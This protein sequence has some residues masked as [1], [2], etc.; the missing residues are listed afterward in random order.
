MPKHIP[1]SFYSSRQSPYSFANYHQQCVLNRNLSLN[2]RGCNLSR[3]PSPNSIPSPAK[4]SHSPSPGTSSVLSVSLPLPTPAG[5]SANCAISV[6]A[7]AVTKRSPVAPV[8]RFLRVVRIPERKPAKVNSRVDLEE[9]S[10]RHVC[11]GCSTRIKYFYKKGEEKTNP[12]EAYFC[13]GCSQ[14]TCGTKRKDGYSCEIS[15]CIHCQRTMCY[16]HFNPSN[17]TFCYDCQDDV[18]KF[19]TEEEI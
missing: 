14:W 18:L 13:D 1:L 9:K 12:E 4:S 10:I 6:S 7:E 11:N 19:C 2:P 17:K 16:K 5:L 15:L 3:S 8:T